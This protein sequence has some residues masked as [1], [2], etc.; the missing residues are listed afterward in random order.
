MAQL[1]PCLVQLLF[2]MLHPLCQLLHLLALPRQG[3]LRLLHF[4]RHVREPHLEVGG[5]L[6]AWGRREVAEPLDLETGAAHRRPH[7]RDGD[8]PVLD[9][10]RLLRIGQGRDGLLDD[11]QGRRNRGDHDGATASAQRGLQ[12]AG[13]LGVPVWHPT[14]LLAQGRDHT[15]QGEETLVDVFPL[16]LLLQSAS[17]HLALAL[18]RFLRQRWRDGRLL[19]CHRRLLGALRTGEVNQVQLPDRLLLAAVAGGTAEHLHREDAVGPAAPRVDS[20]LCDA[21][22]LL[23]GADQTRHIVQRRNWHLQQ[24]DA[25]YTTAAAGFQEV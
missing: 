6:A 7:R 3:S 15:A 2:G 22:P 9:S 14:A 10:S 24:S 12:Q 25:T 8:G 20:R 13:Q 11:G 5:P 17:H 16:A 21:A 19:R 1:V 4:L 18:H 23:G